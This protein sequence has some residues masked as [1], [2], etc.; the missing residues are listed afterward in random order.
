MDQV[1]ASV[2]DFDFYPISRLEAQAIPNLD[3]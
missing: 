3:R 2:V 1:A